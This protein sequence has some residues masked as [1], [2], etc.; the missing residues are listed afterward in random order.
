MGLENNKTYDKL[1]FF[2]FGEYLW[3]FSCVFVVLMSLLCFWCLF[4]P[5]EFLSCF[6]HVLQ[7]NCSVFVFFGSLRLKI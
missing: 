7:F 4:V 6:V 1:R 3:V 5:F 2:C